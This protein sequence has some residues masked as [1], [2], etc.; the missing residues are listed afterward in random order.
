[1]RK[2]GS[3]HSDKTLQKEKGGSTIYRY[4]ESS[5]VYLTPSAYAPSPSEMDKETI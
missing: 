4:W 1:L 2:I 3:T 5:L